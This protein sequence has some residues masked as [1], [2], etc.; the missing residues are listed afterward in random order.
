[1]V[2]QLSQPKNS[3]LRSWFA[4]N[5]TLRLCNFNFSAGPVSKAIFSHKSV[6]QPFPILKTE[7]THS[8]ILKLPQ[9]YFFTKKSWYIISNYDSPCMKMGVHFTILNHSKMSRLGTRVS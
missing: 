7:K 5:I 4:N 1:M 3:D 9:K 6:T 2:D 8:R